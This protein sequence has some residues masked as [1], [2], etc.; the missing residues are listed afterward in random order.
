MN[1]KERRQVQA[2][3]R[4]PAAA[5]GLGPA[6]GDAAALFARGVAALQGQRF[7]EAEGLFRHVAALEPGHAEAHNWLGVACQQQGKGQEALWHLRK[8]AELAPDSPDFANNLGITELKLGDLD[9]AAAAF[10]KAL[11]LNP[12]LAQARYNL[13]LVFQRQRKRAKA[14]ACF[15]QAIALV[16]NYANAYLSLGNA[17]SDAGLHDEA[18]AVLRRL[19]AFAPGV[20]AP[21]FNLAAALRAAQRF[22]EAAEVARQILSLDPNNVVAHN[23]MALFLWSARRHREAEAAARH[24]IALDPNLPDAHCTLGTVLTTLGRLD[25]ARAH[26]EKA[27]ALEPNYPEAVY[28]L[29]LASKADSTPDLA[30]RAEALLKSDPPRDQAAALRFALGKI[31]DDNGDYSRAFENYRAGNELLKREPA[32]DAANWAAYVDRMIAAFPPGFFAQRKSFGSDSRRPMFIV[33]MPRSGTTLVEQIIA[34]HPRAAAGDELEIIPSLT[35]TLARR[36][37]AAAPYPEC[38]TAM[39]EDKAREL[40]TEYLANLD[41][42]SATAERV[43]DKLPQNFRDLGFIALLFPQATFI[44]CRRDPVDTCLSCYF[45]KFDRHL[46]YTYD[47]ESLGAYYREYRRLM[48]HWRQVLPVSILD[49][50]YE[51]LVE[52]Q[53]A[54]SRRIVAHCGLEWDDRCLD[55]HKTERPVLTASVWQVR[56]P[57][58]KT[59]VARWRRYESFLG[60]LRAALEGIAP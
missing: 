52:N 22:E 50:D 56:Q 55:F 17:L 8:A 24:A 41:A 10:E 35:G 28:Q 31:Y 42:I 5:A 38:V 37:G 47:L 43:T 21:L 4:A 34:S 26:L 7:Q 60:P 9:A 3:G 27:L 12:E 40:T 46:A 29:T 51:E 53:E 20:P 48:A 44:H 25:E 33:G 57:L 2:G 39:D 19:V 45:A 15:R 16:P 18:I 11:A 58:Y 32:F 23:I 54:V 14:I 30:A 6:G 1:R 13:G 36:L 49:V 59:A